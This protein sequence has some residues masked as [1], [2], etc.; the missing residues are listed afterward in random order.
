M[1]QPEAI[2]PDGP[3]TAAPPGQG[4]GARAWVALGALWFI[5]VLNFLDRQLLSILAKPIQDS[6]QITDSQLGLLGGLY[7]AMFYCFIA[8]P[9]GWLAD[10]TNRVRVLAIACGIWSAA[11]V[12]CGLSR[13]YTQL[14]VARMTVGFGEAGGVPPSYAII[15]DY[16]PP[17]RRGMA[18]GLYNLGPPI[19]AA[20]GIAFGASIAAA[21]SWRDA[22]LVV[23]AVGIVAAI[24]VVFAV[25]EPRR[26]GL[27]GLAVGAVQHKAGFL[28]TLKMFFTNPALLLASF[29]SG[30]T[31]FITYGLGNFATLFLMREKGMALADVAVWYA[32]VVGVGMSAGIFCS[33]WAIDRFTRRSKRAY[34]L[35]P[36]LSLVLAIP[37]YCAFVWAPT[38]PLALAFLTGPTF[39]NY[40]YLSS[41]VALVQAEVRPNQRVMSGALLLLVMN[42]IGLGLGPTYVGAASD[43][44][45]ASHPDH[46]LQ[47]ALYT[48]VPFYLLAIG[49]FLWLARVLGRRTPTEVSQ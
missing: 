35:V 45:R 32:L 24:A 8:I 15:A 41:S 36:A 43:F 29:G 28:E 39:L 13:T 27:D 25:R 20:L 12:A 18:L 23:G 4:V 16:F 19:G 2:V 38:W 11:T 42:F 10:R 22:F 30:A 3:M 14:A 5:Y 48:L 21:F 17:H 1:S 31:Q 6:L 47:M 40:F 37:F 7:F 9:V 44:F 34:G 26:G 49:L 33:G 46:S